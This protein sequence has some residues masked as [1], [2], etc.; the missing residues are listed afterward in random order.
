VS[1]DSCEAGLTGYGLHRDLVAGE[2]RPARCGEASALSALWRPDRGG[3]AGP[4][5]GGNAGSRARTGGRKKVERSA[6]HV[7]RTG[8]S[9]VRRVLVE[10]AWAYR[11]RASMSAEIRER[12]KGVAPPALCAHE[13]PRLHVVRCLR[14]SNEIWWPTCVKPSQC[15]CPEVRSVER[16]TRSCQGWLGRVFGWPRGSPRASD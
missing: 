15:S 16:Q 2:D 10:A 13:R 14:C 11:F 5:D 1:F 3:S 6:R 8:N 4:G 9:H 7:T 12:N